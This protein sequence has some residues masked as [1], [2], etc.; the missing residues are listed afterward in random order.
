MTGLAHWMEPSPFGHALRQLISPDGQPLGMSFGSGAYAVTVGMTDQVTFL[1]KKLAEHMRVLC[2]AARITAEG[3]FAQYKALFDRLRA[4]FDV[5]VFNLNYDT[6]LLTAWPGPSPA[7]G[8]KASLIQTEFTG[9]QFG[10]SLTI[11]ME[12]SINRSCI[13]SA[14]MSVGKLI[15]MQRSS[16]VIRAMPPIAGQTT[17][18][19]PGRA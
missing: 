18:H 11:C 5:G 2:G 14:T 4:T 17:G 13:R 6:A 16:M 9:A 19:F 12:V 8:P 15:S 7:L 1:L 10:V 3:G